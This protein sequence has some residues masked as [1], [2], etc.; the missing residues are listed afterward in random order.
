MRLPMHGIRRR[1]VLH[2][3]RAGHAVCRNHERARQGG[4]DHATARQAVC[5]GDFRLK[6]IAGCWDDWREKASCIAK[7]IA[8]STNRQTSIC[9]G[10]RSSHDVRLKVLSSRTG[11]ARCARRTRHARH[12]GTPIA[13]VGPVGPFHFDFFIFLKANKHVQSL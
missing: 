9:I 8:R 10:R 3:Q 2:G 11:H 12:A 5:V 7:S 13:P 6:T 4:R 1:A